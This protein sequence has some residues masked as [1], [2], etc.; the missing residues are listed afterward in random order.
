MKHV[1]LIGDG[2]GDYPLG[3]LGGRTPL[4]AAHTPNLDSLAA[5][6][7]LGRAK[8]VPDGMSP[9]S[10][11]A[12]MSLMG[13]YPEGLITGRAPLEA[14]SLG[15]RPGPDEL[16]FRLNLV[17]LGFEGPGIIMRDHSAGHITTAE[18][19]ELVKALAEK[20]PFADGQRVFPG[21][22]YRHL[23]LWPGLSEEG[24][25]SLPPHDYRSQDVAGLLNLP[26]MAPL[27]KMIKLSWEIL[28]GHP[29]N[30]ARRAQGR[31]PANS[32]WL[33]GQGRPPR[34]KTYQERFGLKGAAVSAVDLVKGLG[35]YAGL[36]PV[37][38]PGATGWLDTD[39]Q[40]KVKAALTALANDDFALIHLEAPDEAGHQGDLKAKMEAIE[41]FDA[42]IVGP[43]LEGLKGRPFRVLAA[44]DHYTPLSIA[45]HSREPVPFVMYPPPSGYQPSG[46]AYSEKEAEAAGV[47]IDPGARLAEMLF[48]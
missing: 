48:A 42:K 38:V 19:G 41:N 28:A 18:A 4:E 31:L 3:E 1:I 44:C 43:V 10:D 29:V 24:L 8:N 33:W 36:D 14:A 22:S 30:Q 39:H 5:G 21:V 6:G 27:A 45:T 23:L 12:I 13:Y 17:S 32:I 25:P 2:M 40:A 9:G 16:A 7:L 34:I 26:Q 47:L 11:V 20:M 15:V 46:R 35:V 37:L